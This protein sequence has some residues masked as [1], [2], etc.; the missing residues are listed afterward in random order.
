M[1]KRTSDNLLIIFYRNPEKGQVKSQLAATIGDD[2]AYLIYLELVR[3]TRTTTLLLDIDKAVYYSNKVENSDIW[4]DEFRKYV[5]RGNNIGERI[6]NAFADGFSRGYKSI[7]IIGTDCFELSSK[8]IREAFQFLKDHD[9]V[10]GPAHDGGYYLLGMNKL[11]QQ[12]FTNKKWSTPDESEVT[13]ND[14]AQSGLSLFE[15]TPLQYIDTE[16]DLPEDLR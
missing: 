6:Q 10:V 9:I 8:E 2:R 1:E 12:V 16:E 11:H 13:M 14:I 3:Q 7:C 4:K 5:Q 15:M